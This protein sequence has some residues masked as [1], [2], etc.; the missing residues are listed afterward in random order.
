MS[1]DRLA[2]LIRDDAIDIL[3]DL[4]G[5]TGK[6]RLGVFARDVEA[7]YRAAWRTGAPPTP[8]PTERRHDPS[9]RLDPGL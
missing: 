4:A 9:C 2:A 7:A 5:N 6:H 3:V 1:D 8:P